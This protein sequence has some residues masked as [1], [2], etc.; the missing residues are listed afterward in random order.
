MNMEKCKES[1]SMLLEHLPNELFVEIFSYMNGIDTI[2]AFSQL[3]NRFECLLLKCCQS[4]NFKSISKRKFDF[5]LQKYK[6][7][8]QC[9]SLQLCNDDN[10]PGQIEYFCKYY[11][12]ITL[13]PYLESLSILKIEPIYGYTFLLEQLQ[14][15][16]N[17]KLLIIE[18]IC[19]ET[20]FKFNLPKLKRLILKS[21]TN[22]KWIN[23][24]IIIRN[25]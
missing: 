23:V 3:N 2:F 25:I 12:L 9:K 10:T 16:T 1:V 24:N 13:C 14:S 21:C 8:F 17:L 6:N 11:S 15:L 4:F 22:T 5:I 7:I 20:M 18:S 19:G